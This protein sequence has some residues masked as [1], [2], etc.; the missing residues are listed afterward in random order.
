MIL[1]DILSRRMKVLLF[2]IVREFEF[3]LPIAPMDIFRKTMIVGRPA[4][5]TDPAAGSQL[6]LLIRP[7]NREV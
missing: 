6:P 5:T 4:L 2:T 3:E 7:V 1:I